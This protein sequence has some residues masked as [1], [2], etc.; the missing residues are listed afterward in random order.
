MKINNI[1]SKPA[2]LAL[3]DGLVLE[4]KSFG[5]DIDAEGELVFNTEM[6]GYQEVLTDPSYRGQMVVMTYPHIGNY[7]VVDGDEESDNIWVEA[8]IVKELCRRFYK[9]NSV[10][11]LDTYLKE[12]KIPGI[13]GID[14]RFLTRHIRENGSLKAVLSSIETNKDV[15]IDRAKESPGLE[16]RDLVT[17]VSCKKSFFFGEKKSRPSCVAYDLGG[18]RAIF[19][20]LSERFDLE[21]I[22]CSETAETVLKKGPSLVFLSNGPGDPSALDY[23]ISNVKE[24]LGKIPIVGICL[25][26]Q[27]LAQVL[28]GKT[29]KLKFGHHGVN[30]PVREVTG[31]QVDITSQNHSF[32]VDLDSLPKDVEV[33]HLNL[34]DMT[35]EGLISN[36]LRVCSVQYHPEAS[37][38]P[39]DARKLFDF[40]YDFC[41]SGKCDS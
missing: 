12:Y 34:N 32:S 5:F 36:E 3:E 7:G 30:H 15:L 19:K 18:K 22:P 2:I 25:G 21:V 1:D 28:G 13:E 6:T 27:I 37:P 41:L 4:G 14:T 24:L 39:H 8:F 33:T 11:D 10:K 20:Q 16:G 9:Y 23:I 29:Y 17:G 31:S 26:H 38:G 40:F 35:C